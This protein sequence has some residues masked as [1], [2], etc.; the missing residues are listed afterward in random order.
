VSI[1]RNK[2]EQLQVLIDWGNIRTWELLAIQT[3]EFKQDLCKR[4]KVKN[5]NQLKL[6]Q[7]RKK[8]KTKKH[9]SGGPSIPE[10]QII[11]NLG[12]HVFKLYCMYCVLNAFSNAI[13]D[14]NHLSSMDMNQARKDIGG[15]YQRA[16]NWS[17]PILRKALGNKKSKFCIAYPK[18]KYNNGF[19]ALHD[20][21]LNNFLEN[22]HKILL[23]EIILQDNDDS[24]MVALICDHMLIL[25]GMHTKPIDLKLWT[26]FKKQY[27]WKDQKGVWEVNLYDGNMN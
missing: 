23:V 10:S 2:D 19:R 21:A 18:P 11:D 9:T 22:N 14:N 17:I 27:G 20:R 26:K 6:G 3:D 1:K 5:V 25:D 12:L 7:L 16:G 4:Q 13:Q 15:T 24:H 8:K